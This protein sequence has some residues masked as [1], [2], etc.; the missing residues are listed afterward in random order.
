MDTWHRTKTNKVK[1]QHTKLK[2]WVTQNTP[3]AGM[4]KS[5]NKRRT[6]KTIAKRQKDND[7]ENTTQK[8]KDRT[9]RTPVKT[10]VEPRCPG[11]IYMFIGWETQKNI[12]RL[13]NIIITCSHISKWSHIFL[14]RKFNLYFCRCFIKLF[15]TF[16]TL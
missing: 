2:R 3:K 5:V 13:Y 1:T 8:T 9:T 11:G 7:L 6:D 16:Q 10:K 14:G 4:N 15:R 12:W